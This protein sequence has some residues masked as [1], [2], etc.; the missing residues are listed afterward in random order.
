MNY[1]YKHFLLLFNSAEYINN[2]F[3]KLKKYM[4]IYF[5]K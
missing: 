3:N 1:L 4:N 2:V 5:Y